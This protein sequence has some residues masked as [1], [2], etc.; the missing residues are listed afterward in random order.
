[1]IEHDDS[2]Q[3]EQTE[4]LDRL[5]DGCIPPAL[6]RQPHEHPASYQHFLAYLR[7]GRQR[8]YVRLSRLLHMDR[9]GIERLSVRYHWVE[10]ARVY[11]ALLEQ[12]Q[13]RDLIK[14]ACLQTL[15]DERNAA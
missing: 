11:D 7:L 2:E 12:A 14:Q 8:G 10:R 6:A 5:L 15:R 3:T 13:L 4:Q 9:R 1:V